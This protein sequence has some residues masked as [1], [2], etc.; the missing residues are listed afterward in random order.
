MASWQA[1]SRCLLKQHL[2]L[3]GL[4]LSESLFR[5]LIEVREVLVSSGT[6]PLGS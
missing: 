1:A 2:F 3:F 5:V 6:H 4:Q